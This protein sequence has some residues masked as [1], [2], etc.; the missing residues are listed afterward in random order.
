MS[1]EEREAQGAQNPIKPKSMPQQRRGYIKR[2]PIENIMWKPKNSRQLGEALAT[3]VTT[4]PPSTVSWFWRE[5]TQDGNPKSGGRIQET[6]DM[7]FSMYPGG[8]DPFTPEQDEWWRT[9][10]ERDLEELPAH[11]RDFRNAMIRR[12]DLPLAL[13]TDYRG[14]ENMNRVPS[15]T[16]ELTAIAY[17]YGASVPQQMVGTVWNRAQ[18]LMGTALIQ[19]EWVYSPEAI[20]GVHATEGKGDPVVGGEHAFPESELGA[21]TNIDNFISKSRLPDQGEVVLETASNNETEERMNQAQKREAA[22]AKARFNRLYEA[23]ETSLEYGE[24][25]DSPEMDDADRIDYFADEGGDEDDLKVGEEELDDVIDGAKTGMQAAQEYLGTESTVKVIQAVGRSMGK[26]LMLLGDEANKQ[27]GPL[28]DYAA[29]QF[30]GISEYLEEFDESTIEKVKENPE[31]LDGSSSFRHFLNVAFLH[32]AYLRWRRDVKSNMTNLLGEEGVSESTIKK[33]MGRV[34]RAEVFSAES[35]SRMM[36]GS[37]EGL[38]RAL[39]GNKA[40]TPQEEIR[41][42]SIANR[43]WEVMLETKAD[44]LLEASVKRWQALSDKNKI[45][46]YIK[47]LSKQAEED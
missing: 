35:P 2:A 8:A 25:V 34:D 1:N 6:V 5:L 21:S 41:I 11:Q 15:T 30:I 38:F 45:E 31:L 37:Q 29:K 22:R 44:D 43:T 42:R 33:I 46:V 32:P 24:E 10:Y 3:V 39:G 14:P 47:A 27:L 19:P 36:G 9:D 23:L 40:K 12:P 28:R 13:P 17:D 4:L 18:T 20:S 7:H 26:V 16:A